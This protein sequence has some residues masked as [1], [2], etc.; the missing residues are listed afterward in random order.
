VH[1]A[2]FFVGQD[3]MTFRNSAVAVNRSNH[4]TGNQRCH[5]TPSIVTESTGAGPEHRP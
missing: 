5:Q 1:A 2:G 4:A 3:I